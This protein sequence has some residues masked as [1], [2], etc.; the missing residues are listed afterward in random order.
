MHP[1]TSTS[2][3]CVHVGCAALPSKLI[4]IIGGARMALV[5][6]AMNHVELARA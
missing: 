1:V 4:I 6:C 5:H 3:L 2:V